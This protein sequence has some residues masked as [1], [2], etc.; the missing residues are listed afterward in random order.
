MGQ[1]SGHHHAWGSA[2]ES[3]HGEREQ[4]GLTGPYSGYGL[5]ALDTFA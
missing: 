2:L 5:G 3:N 4:V 1:C